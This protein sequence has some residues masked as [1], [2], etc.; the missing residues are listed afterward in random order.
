MS[1]SPSNTAPAALPA[2]LPVAGQPFTHGNGFDA[3]SFRHSQFDGAMDPLVM[4]DH[5]TMSEPTFGA[6]PHAGMS[7]VSILFEDSVGRFHNR[8][9]LGHRIDLLPGDLYWLKAGRGAVHDEAP[10]PGS[11]THGLQVF[12][13]LPAAHKQDAPDAL[14]ISH[15]DMPVL[16]GEGYRVRLVLGETGGIEGARS[17]A[18]PMTILDGQLEPAG[19]FRHASPAGHAVWIL[20]VEGELAV[21]LDETVTP[22]ANPAATPTSADALTHIPAGQ[23][24]ALPAADLARTLT[25]VSSKGAHFALLQAVPVREAFVQQGPFVMSSQEEINTVQAAYARGE[26]G[27]VD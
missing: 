6:H 25:L 27:S 7:A 17:P 19:T 2:P 4:V 23:A 3:L 20:A 9:S 24:V 26:L 1:R 21:R 11:R 14:H 13:N 5:Y 8:D 10:T 22:D 12:V 18:L 15:T 16:T